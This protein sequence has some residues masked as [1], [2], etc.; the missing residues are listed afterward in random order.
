MSQPR[1]ANVKLCAT[2]QSS[3][4]DIT[5]GNIKEIKVYLTVRQDTSPNRQV[6]NYKESLL[7]DFIS[8]IRGYLVN[9]FHA[10][11][12]I[13]AETIR[14]FYSFCEL[15]N[16]PTDETNNIMENLFNPMRMFFQR[17]S[18][19]R[20]VETANNLINNR[21]SDIPQPV[22]LQQIQQQLLNQ[23]SAHSQYANSL[24]PSQQQYEAADS[25]QRQQMMNQ[26]QYTNSILPSQQYYESVSPQEPEQVMDRRHSNESVE[27][28]QP[29]PMPVQQSVQPPSE[30]SRFVVDEKAPREVYETTETNETP[31]TGDTEDAHPSRN[32][33]TPHTLSRLA[34]IVFDILST[35]AMKAPN[36][37][38]KTRKGMRKIKNF[39]FNITRVWLTNDEVETFTSLITT[40]NGNKINNEEN[41]TSDDDGLVS[42]QLD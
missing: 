10:S 18:V 34:R 13:P 32:S 27:I 22:T 7:Q 39:I 6:Q 25:K 15:L 29:T 20:L 38:N 8:V 3:K 4:I 1:I 16:R 5:Y 12:E 28:K 23:L 9:E 14:L 41:S 21:I 2:Q 19:G 36:F 42:E 40:L 11:M 35:T 30:T 26:S 24:R 31:D 37:T 33:I 17:G